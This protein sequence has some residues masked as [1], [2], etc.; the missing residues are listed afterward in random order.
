VQTLR[1]LLVV[2]VVCVC[3]ALA[4]QWQDRIDLSHF[5]T[6]DAALN[7]LT[8][9]YWPTYR[10]VLYVYGSGKLIAQNYP[11]LSFSRQYGLFPTCKAAL[12][13][14]KVRDVVRLMIKVRFFD[15]PQKSFVYATASDDMEDAEKEWQVHSIA[16]D[17]GTTHA[18]RDF[19][20]GTYLGKQE[21]IPQEFAAVEAFLQRLMKETFKDTPCK[22]DYYVRP[23]SVDRR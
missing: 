9:A 15:L 19:A 8:I 4:S 11:G 23:P 20:A 6:D 18:Q 12:S 14:E 7:T 16:L 13:P 21:S 10:Q 3:S 5:L 17:D 22:L 2:L 1:G